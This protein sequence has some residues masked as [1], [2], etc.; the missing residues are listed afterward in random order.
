MDEFP[1]EFW[2]LVINCFSDSRVDSDIAMKVQTRNIVKSMKNGRDLM[3]NRIF[4]N[5]FSFIQ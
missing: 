3:P 1:A 2:T 4:C 5:Y